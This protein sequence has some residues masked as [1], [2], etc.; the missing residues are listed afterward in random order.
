MTTKKPREFWIDDIL[1][2]DRPYTKTAYI[3]FQDADDK[4]HFIIH[5]REVLP[6]PTDAELMEMDENCGHSWEAGF[7]A[8][9]A[10]MKG[11]R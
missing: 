2:I 4:G 11:E 1:N 6:E 5:V 10:W 7:R 8:A 9:L 3:H